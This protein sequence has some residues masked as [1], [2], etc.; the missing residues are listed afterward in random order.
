MDTP[1][2]QVIIDCPAPEKVRMSNRSWG[3]QTFTDGLSP[4]T[5]YHRPTESAYAQG[6]PWVW[7][8]QC[9]PFNSSEWP[10]FRHT[11]STISTGPFLQWSRQ[12]PLITPSPVFSQYTLRIVKS[13]A[14]V[15]QSHLIWCR[16]QLRH[17]R[18][19]AARHLRSFQDL[20]TL[21]RVSSPYID[22]IT[23]HKNL[24]YFSSTEILTRRQARWSGFLS[25]F[26]MVICFREGTLGEKR[27]L[28]LGERIS[29]LQREIGT[30]R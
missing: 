26:N 5:R 25:A 7:S 13:I 4:R 16:A 2:I 22:V 8:P 24:G 15:L 30:I 17:S 14:R 20:T 12:T 1:K 9:E 3:L 6:R 10:L 19:G 28:I 29:T 23:D 11:S 18:Q 27:I 21:S